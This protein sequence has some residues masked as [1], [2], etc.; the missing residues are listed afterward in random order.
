LDV[1]IRRFILI[2][3]ALLVV[4]TGFVSQ[5]VLAGDGPPI[6]PHED[7]DVAKVI[8]SSLSLLR[9]Y[10]A[11]LDFIL[12]QDEPGSVANLAKMPFANVPVY[13]DSATSGFAG[14][15]T[16][17][18]HSLVGLFGLWNQENDLIR[19]YR[20]TEAAGIYRQLIAGIPQARQEL[21][22]LESATVATG[23][24]LKIDSLSPQSELKLTYAEVIAKIQQLSGML[25]LLSRSL[26]PETLANLLKNPNLTLTSAQIADLLKNANSLTP[27]Q[28]AELL[29]PTD[30]T[31]VVNPT[32]A[33]VGDEISFQGSL[34][35][36]GAPMSQRKV[37]ILLNNTE[38]LV[39]TTDDQGN[40]SGK[41]QLPY[42]YVHAAEVQALYF[43]ETGDTGVYLGAASP[44]IPLT[45]LFY[46]VTLDLK[47]E[48]TAYPGRE[49]LLTGTFDYNGAPP[50][51]QRPVELYLDDIL[52]SQFSAGTGFSQ[53]I[54]IGANISP[55]KHALSASVA[56]VGRYAPAAADSLLEVKLATPVL[57]LH[58][59]RISF[60]PGSI[61]I[62][63]R[64]YSEIGPL[65]NA[66]VAV[67]AG[68]A[69]AQVK[70]TAEGTFNSKLR[71]GLG[72][73]LL[74]N[75]DISVN[76]QPLEPWNAPLST[77][78]TTFVINALSC[79]LILIVLVGLG[80]YLPRRLKKWNL[81]PPGKPGRLAET[82]P[83]PV[84]LLGENSTIL[85]LKE[86][87]RDDSEATSNPIMYWYRI[88]LKLVQRLTRA[89]LK[90]QQTLREYAR[91]SSTALGPAG[92]Y[93]LELTYIIE[94][95]LYG[96]GQPSK[97]DAEKSRQLA[98]SI[99]EETGSE[100]R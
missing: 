68:N 86:A 89:I 65:Q 44:V 7:P 49:V 8:F 17:F 27:E 51:A 93:F 46:E 66:G 6:V 32:T 11:S 18:T 88:A 94:R 25:D 81:F 50:P 47:Q 84:T 91:Q 80:V 41:L 56:A 26:L 1:N 22:G 34:T 70:T 83:A 38:T 69:G 16:D 24:Y 74:G 79:G 2:A 19:Q 61:G 23:A 37:S 5:P 55:G 20:L 92:K 53:T 12:Q 72:L 82:V 48:G 97:A 42:R 15:G 14:Y 21:T 67:N 33:Y 76:V 40:Y 60:I 3:I 90:P 64:L 43:P 73:S 99:Q 100:N 54:D 87:K 35:S 30:L 9:Y 98:R 78:K 58:L 71:M 10:S 63:G 77:T 62:S 59:P 39:V 57:E 95:K 45:V 31:L 28:V 96:K 13:L 75:Q 4:L 36:A 29:R 85:P 52:V